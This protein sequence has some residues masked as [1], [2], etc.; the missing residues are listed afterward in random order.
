MTEL[1]TCTFVNAC[2]GKIEMI[3]DYAIGVEDN[4]L[5]FLKMV[6]AREKMCIYQ[7]KLMYDNE[8]LIRDKQ[9]IEQCDNTEHKLTFQL[10]KLHNEIVLMKDLEWTDWPSSI[11]T[12]W[13]HSIA[14]IPQAKTMN[15]ICNESIYHNV[16]GVG[17]APRG[18]GF[19]IVCIEDDEM[20]HYKLDWV[21]KNFDAALLMI[22]TM[23]NFYI[24]I[25]DPT[26]ENNWIEFGN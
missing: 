17:R 20:K 10:I 26:Y 23:P 21:P 15:I 3:S 1:T 16:T 13:G 6:C 14:T 7:T 11:R 12:D 5:T 4:G 19:V 18:W 9:I 24:Q 2:N 22:N 8:I 25:I